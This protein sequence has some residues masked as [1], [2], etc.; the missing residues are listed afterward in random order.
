ML[1]EFDYDSYLRLHPNNIKRVIRA[2]EIYKTTGITMTEQIK[3]S[4]NIPS[5]FDVKYFALNTDRE[6]IYRRINKR[7]DLMVDAGLFEEVESLY[8]EGLDLSY[9]SMQ[10]IGYKELVDAIKNGSDI[11]AALDKIKQESRRYAKRQLSWLRR[12]SEI[13]WILHRKTPQIEE[14]LQLSTEFLNKNR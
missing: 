7:V 13:N 5:A 9:K 10:A 8:K 4:K 12:D 3:N 14:A 11:S 1:K 2:I 6:V